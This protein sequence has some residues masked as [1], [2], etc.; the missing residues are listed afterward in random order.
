MGWQ[1]SREE[2]P[3]LASPATLGPPRPLYLVVVWDPWNWAAMAVSQEL[4]LEAERDARHKLSSCSGAAGH[5]ERHLPVPP[6]SPPDHVGPL[7]ASLRPLL[8]PANERRSP[9]AYQSAQTGVS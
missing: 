5:G 1:E 2:E 7:M 6:S 4:L 9:Q 8:L 3:L